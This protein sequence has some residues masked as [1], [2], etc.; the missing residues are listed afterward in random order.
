MPAKP[1]PK[2]GRPWASTTSHTSPGWPPLRTRGR[3]CGRWRP[4][5]CAQ[6]A[7]SSLGAAL[8][9]PRSWARLSDEGIAR[10]IAILERCENTLC[11]P[12]L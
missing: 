8:F 10:L 6:R 7:A 9:H 11:W 1:G 4:R 5:A 3:R 2:C 12:E